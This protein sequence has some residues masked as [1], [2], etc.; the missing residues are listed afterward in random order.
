MR[1]RFEVARTVR[2]GIAIALGA[3]LFVSVVWAQATPAADDVPPA[4]YDLVQG[5][6]NLGE[7]GVAITRD[8]DG[9]VSRSWVTI[10]G[11]LEM[12][13]EL[14]AAPD[15][16]ARAYTVEGTAQGTE[17][18]VEGAFHPG[19]VTLTVEQAG[20]SVTFELSSEEPL[21]VLDNNFI[22]GFQLFVDGFLQDGVLAAGSERSAAVVVPQ[23]AALGTITLRSSTE[24]VGFELRGETVQAWRL[25]GVFQVGPQQLAITVWADDDGRMLE[26]DQAAAGV[27]FVLRPAAEASGADGGAG[28]L[29]AAVDG[30]AA[31]IARDAACVEERELR[32]AS[33]GATLA[34]TLDVPVASA[35]GEA[36]PAPVLLLLPGSGAVDIDGNSPPV[37]RNSGYRQLAYALGCEGYAVLRI[38][39]LGIPPSTGD[40]NAV[41]ID[42]YVQNTADWIGRLT[43]EPDV[44]ARR[45]GL[46][47]HS[48]GGLVA[49]A[50]AAHGAVAADVV[51]LVATAGRPFDVL[52]EEQLMASAVR[53]GADAAYLET[54]RA[55]TLAA[56]D[57]IRAV[58]GT[59]LE[60][61]G[62]LANNPVAALFAH[63]AG[64]LRSEFELDPL[65]LAA[66]IRVPVVIFQGEKDLQVLP[67]DARLLAEANP[68]AT[69]LLLPDLTHNL[70]EVSGPALEGMVPTPDA[71]ISETL[72]RALTTFLHGHLRSAAR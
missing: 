15:G 29:T 4:V 65:E 56:L 62:D 61:E 47:G 31:R 26:L 51:V 55:Q 49:L 36:A 6:A 45:F 68:D 7:A 35:R 34:G 54:F 30:G 40:G 2:M 10:P 63:A 9:A 71:A 3:L 33:T 1:R 24:R 23:A 69:L 70:V 52:L 27:R 48:E 64:L 58:E 20:Q 5:Q 43:Q 37:L 60:L 22:D 67:V 50:A 41:T 8:E 11:V 72:V 66:A 57:A 16:S 19:G 59:R 21:Y 46:I 28:T 12:R 53:G 44:D 39:K 25:D 32:V 18:R 42:T 38:A 13:D 14:V 17:F